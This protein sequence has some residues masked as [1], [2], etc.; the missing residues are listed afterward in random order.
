MTSGAP[1]ALRAR[2]PGA[3]TV[4]PMRHLLTR[5]APLGCRRCCHR[6]L[7][8]MSQ[9]NPEGKEADAECESCGRPDA[10]LVAV[11]RVYLVPERSRVDDVEHWCA[12]CRS[13]YPH[14]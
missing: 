6:N 12:S 13:Q 10:D 4:V 8:V 3:V 11:T 1:L 9:V 2:S 7:I 5:P 14:E